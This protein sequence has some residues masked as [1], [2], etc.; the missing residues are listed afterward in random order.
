MDAN[1]LLFKRFIMVAGYT[2]VEKIDIY[3]AVDGRLS[4]L[5]PAYLRSI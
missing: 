3:F 2:S 4:A 5:Y 1:C